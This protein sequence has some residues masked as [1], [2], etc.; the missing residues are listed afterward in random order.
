MSNPN[1][2]LLLNEYDKKRLQAELDLEN[3][4]NNFY[5]KNPDILNIND[6]INRISIEISKL[7]Y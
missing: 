5:I 4:L 2:K 3:K 1:L 6:R 7:F